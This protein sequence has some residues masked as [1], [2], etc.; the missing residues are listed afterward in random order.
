MESGIHNG[1]NTRE[2]LTPRQEEILA[3]IAS[4]ST[5]N[6][7]AE[8]L[9]ITL[10]G[11]K[12]HVSEIIAKLGV[13]SR[14]EAVNAWRA[15]QSLGGRFARGLRALLAPI[16]V[17]KVAVT[18]IAASVVAAAAAGGLFLA[19]R[20]GPAESAQE[21]PHSST[22]G[23]VVDKAFFNRV[24][25]I[26]S[27]V[28]WAQIQLNE[29][30]MPSKLVRTED[31]AHTWRNVSPALADQET[32]HAAFFLDP[33][34]AWIL[35]DQLS[36]ASPPALQTRL[37]RV[38]WTTDGGK[39]WRESAPLGP[40]NPVMPLG[41]DRLQLTFA[42]RQHGWVRDNAGTLFR[43]T[44]SGDTWHKVSVSSGT[45][46]QPV[47]N[48]LPA[49]CSIGLTF[50]DGSH[51]YTGGACENDSTGL[52][53]FFRTDDGGVTWKRQSLPLPGN[54]QQSV[55]GCQ[56][57]VSPPSFPTPGDGFL[58]LWSPIPEGSTRSAATSWL[59]T[60]YATHDGG[61]TWQ[62]LG[63]PHI[64]DAYIGGV[65]FVDPTHGWLVDG[66]QDGVNTFRTVDGGLTWEQLPAGQFP[67]FNFISATE[68]W[69]IS[70]PGPASDVW[71]VVHTLDGGETWQPVVPGSP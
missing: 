31:G 21:L 49:S 56:C 36:P 67:G 24:Q 40:A 57:V 55:G 27:E 26:D 37:T 45:N 63:T 14:E 20:G 3:L 5:N 47:T 43:S 25:M 19:M 61:P 30:G 48:R 50:R 58:A 62:V 11:A 39:T 29:S 8:H 9:G 35:V 38:A 28:G 41:A 15:Q 23:Q 12:W 60:V 10:D 70:V 65:H 68:G 13:E 64:G 52:P 42:D 34:H 16:V 7:I 4:G 66:T 17:H 33:A 1:R 18:A 6:Q 44:D 2:S 22:F 53:L 32:I 46:S 71:G 69:A 54:P 59:R 51:G